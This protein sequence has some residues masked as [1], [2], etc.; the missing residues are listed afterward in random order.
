LAWLSHLPVLKDKKGHGRPNTMTVLVAKGRGGLIMDYVGL[1]PMV[2]LE[3]ADCRRVHRLHYSEL[4]TRVAEQVAI[5]CESCTQ[6]LDHDWT[7]IT[8]VQNIIR[9]RMRQAQET[10]RSRVVPGLG[11][12]S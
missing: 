4:L 1:D 9:R 7:T 10:E 11:S 6:P 2:G 8:V 5:F 12:G 3:C